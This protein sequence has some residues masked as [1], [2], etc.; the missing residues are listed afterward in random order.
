[1]LSSF[2]FSSV[3]VSANSCLALAKRRACA[4][5]MEAWDFFTSPILARFARSWAANS[6]GLPSFQRARQPSEARFRVLVYPVQ[7]VAPAGFAIRRSSFPLPI[8]PRNQSGR[9]RDRCPEGHQQCDHHRD[10]R[11][12]GFGHQGSPGRVCAQ[13]PPL[14]AAL[15]RLID[16]RRWTPKMV[17]RALIGSPPEAVRLGHGMRRPDQARRSGGLP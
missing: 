17:K 7:S 6:R 12:K 5:E 2:S 13:T 11:D 4:R 3:C 10:H 16:A 9:Y 8:L 1:M 15:L 14:R